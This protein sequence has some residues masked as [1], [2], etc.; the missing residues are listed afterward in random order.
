MRSL[1]HDLLSFSDFHEV[2]NTFERLG[3]WVSV[4]LPFTIFALRVMGV[5]GTDF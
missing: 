5:V 4:G 3:S 2:L 1:F